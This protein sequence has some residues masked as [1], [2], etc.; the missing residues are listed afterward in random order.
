MPGDQ[1]A[2]LVHEGRVRPPPFED[3]CDDLVDVGF[4]VKPRIGAVGDQP[5]DRPKLDPLARPG[6]R[7]D[8]LRGSACCQYHNSPPKSLKEI[9]GNSATMIY[10]GWGFQTGR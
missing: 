7:G 3:R 9:V 6:S 8:G 2:V 1:D 4:A 10:V 5:F